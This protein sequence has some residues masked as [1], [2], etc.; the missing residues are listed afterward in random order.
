MSRGNS[1]TPGRCRWAGNRPRPE[2]IASAGLGKVHPA[3]R[4]FPQAG[5]EA[6]R[7][8]AL[9]PRPAGGRGQRQAAR[10]CQRGGR[11]VGMCTVALH[12]AAAYSFFPRFICLTVCHR[13]ARGGGR[14]RTP[15]T[16]TSSCSAKSPAL[17]PARVPVALLFLARRVGEKM[18]GMPRARGGRRRPPQ[19]R[20]TGTRASRWRP[21]GATFAA[22]GC[23]ISSNNKR[24][25][26]IMTTLTCRA[27]Q[28]LR[29]R[30]QCRSAPP[31]WR[32]RRRLCSTRRPPACGQAGA[33]A[34]RRRRPTAI[35]SFDPM[36]TPAALCPT[37]RQ[38]A[39]SAK[40]P[41]DR[42]HGVFIGRQQAWRGAER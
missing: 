4:L 28:V 41:D 42:P 27:P 26:R 17:R 21:R 10:R 7:T 40:E 33:G 5:R 12:A 36:K 38:S 39:A 24:K 13:H 15:A 3:P 22:A 6:R 1:C 19:A 35:S 8:Q 23:S 37:G 25:I 20:K 14:E 34:R 18:A 16:N 31:P 29:P 2:R 11:R 9:A 30:V 32:K